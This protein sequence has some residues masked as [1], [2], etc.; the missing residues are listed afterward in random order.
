MLERLAALDVELF[1]IVHRALWPSPWLPVLRFV[2]MAG[3]ARGL[4]VLFVA[5][6]LLAPGGRRL[7]I[8][9]RLLGPVLVA[10]LCMYVLKHLVPTE[11]PRTLLPGVV[12]N[13]T[14]EAHGSWPSGHTSAVFALAVGVLMLRLSGSLPALRWTVAT[15]ACFLIAGA[16]GLG[17]IA[18]G[19]HFPGDV[20]AGAILG[21]SV[22]FF[23]VRILDRERHIFP[24]TGHSLGTK[25]A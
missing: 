17:R 3:E 15:V 18:L 8:V 1:T 6:F 21:S 12:L 20:L 14:V 16:T 9:L 2:Q 19:A 24:V 10:S 5:A 11:R 23:I 13:P 7:E 4:V 22:A 25:P